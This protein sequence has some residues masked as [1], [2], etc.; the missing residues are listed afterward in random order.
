MA[1]RAMGL[2]IQVLNA[3]TERRDRC[4]FCD[5][6]ARAAA[7]LLFVG[8]RSVLSPAGAIQLAALAARHAVPTCYR[9]AR[10]SSKPA[11]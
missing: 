4:G 8:R 6:C 5:A 1:A 11:G 9:L 10:L 7:M 2:Q 3:S